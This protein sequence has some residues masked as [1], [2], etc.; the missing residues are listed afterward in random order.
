MVASR[1]QLG[2]GCEAVAATPAHALGEGRA[3]VLLF[4][5]PFR[6]KFW[7]SMVNLV[8]DCVVNGCSGNI[9]FWCPD[10]VCTYPAYLGIYLGDSVGQL[11]TTPRP[12]AAVPKT[13]SGWRSSSAAFVQAKS[14]CKAFDSTAAL[15]FPQL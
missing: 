3:S 1:H 14:T 8:V 15:I 11:I 13:R 10:S 5:F 12:L 9:S 6:N 4:W 7:N 2:A